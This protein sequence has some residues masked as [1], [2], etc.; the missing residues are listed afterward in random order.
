MTDYMETAKEE[1]KRADHLIFV[2]L[3]YTRTVDM[4]KHVIERIINAI[5]NMF[6]ALLENLDEAGKIEGVP[7]TPI[8]KATLLKNTYPADPMIQE[9]CELFVKLRKII[10]SP[11]DNSCEFRRHVTMTAHLTEDEIVKID[12]DSITDIFK[13]SKEFLEHTEKLIQ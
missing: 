2:S 4:L 11:H 7:S 13:K 6:C 9:F 1:M 12:I 8:Q 10:K 3:K 5:E